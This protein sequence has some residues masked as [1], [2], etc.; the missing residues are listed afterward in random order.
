MKPIV[1]VL[2]LAAAAAFMG[3]VVWSTLQAVEVECEVC[4]EFEGREVCRQG[5]GATQEEALAA[6]QQSTCGGNTSGMA[7]SIACLSRSPNRSSCP[8][9]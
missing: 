4:L 7:E 5:R 1:V 2:I 8:A 6:A 3:V 9:P